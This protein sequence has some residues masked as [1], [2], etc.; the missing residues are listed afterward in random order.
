M[1]EDSNTCHGAGSIPIEC[2]KN[3]SSS[4]SYSISGESDTNL[5]SYA[6]NTRSEA[7][8][9]PSPCFCRSAPEQRFLGFGEMCLYFF[10]NTSNGMTTSPRTWQLTGRFR[11][12]GMFAT[13]FAFNVTSSPRSPLP[14]V[15]ARCKF[16]ATYSSERAE[17]SSFGWARY[18]VPPKVDWLTKWRMS[19]SVVPLSRERIGN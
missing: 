1:V 14:R 18:R 6:Q 13:C 8:A 10:S 7:L 17:P 2:F 3:S 12:V 16:P 4:L 11:R 5:T 15:A 9:F 19:S